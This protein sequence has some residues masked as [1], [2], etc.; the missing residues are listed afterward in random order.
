MHPG[1]YTLAGVLEILCGPEMRNG[2]VIY[3][4]HALATLGEARTE[5]W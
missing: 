2:G 4:M 3:C 5:A 1:A